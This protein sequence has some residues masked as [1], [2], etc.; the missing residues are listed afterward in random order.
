MKKMYNNEK[1][2]DL[3]ITFT[4]SSVKQTDH[5]I[6]LYLTNC[7]IARCKIPKFQLIQDLMCKLCRNAQS[8]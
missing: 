2:K 6:R 1:N 4:G 5:S 7:I 3:N 8:P